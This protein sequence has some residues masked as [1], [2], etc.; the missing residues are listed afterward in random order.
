M[1]KKRVSIWG[2]TGSI[3]TQAL[4]VIGCHPDRFELVTLTARSSADLIFE[5]ALKWKPE[6]VIL[7]GAPDTDWQM[8]FKEAGIRYET[9]SEALMRAASAAEEDMVVNGLVGSAGLLCTV[10]AIRAGVHI[11]LANKEVLVMAGGLINELLE[12]HHVDMIPVDSE[13]SAVWQ[14]LRGESGESIRRIVL[15]ASGGPFRNFSADELKHVSREQALA[16]PNWNMGPK[17]TVDSATMINKALEIIEARWLF[18][19]RPGQIEVVVHPQSILHSMV[20]F[21]DGSLKAQL[22]VPDMRVPIAYALSY[23]ERFEI[24]FGSLD[25]SILHRLDL[26]PPDFERFPALRL[27]YQVLETGGTAPAVLNGADEAAV[28][29]FLEDRIHFIE[30]VALIEETL[31]QHQVIARPGLEQ[32]LEADRW[33][34]ETIGRLIRSM[35]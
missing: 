22:S 2:S 28:Q 10:N 34:R 24:P 23:P 29:A 8:R 11:A 21:M 9:G 14:C 13:H 25:L 5:Q 32:I 12:K 1:R 20:E 4:E 27:A 35:K 18:G 33:A 15:T 30:I 31:Q 26:M 16:H 3:G 17:I 6:R 7:T 19:V